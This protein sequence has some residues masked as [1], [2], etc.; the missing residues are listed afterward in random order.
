MAGEAPQVGGNVPS[1]PLKKASRWEIYFPADSD[2]PTDGVFVASFPKI[3]YFWPTVLTLLLSGLLQAWTKMPPGTLA[4]FAICVTT[5]NLLVI[6]QD[7]DQ[8][9]FLILLLVLLAF[10]LCL[11][12]LRMKQITLLSD[13][14][15][16]LRSLDVQASTHTYLITGSIMLIQ[17]VWGLFKPSFDYWRLEP[18]EFVHYVLPFGRDMSIPRAGHT[19]NKE[20][21]DVLEYLL[22]FGG[23]SIVFREGDRVVARISDIPM[24]GRRMQRIEKMLGVT[25][26]A[27]VQE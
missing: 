21:P 13:L 11:W 2:E 15:G 10:G 23:G 20:V 8:K 3:L 5:I 14:V 24:L 19:V 7:F 26:V 16:W 12:I 1:T 18:N 22:T 9:K 4:W 27:T 17:F 25:R 6:V